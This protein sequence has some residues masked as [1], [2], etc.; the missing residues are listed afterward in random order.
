MTSRQHLNRRRTVVRAVF[1]KLGKTWSSGQDPSH[2]Y[3]FLLVKKNARTVGGEPFT[4]VGGITAGQLDTIINTS[5][6]NEE[7]ADRVIDL[8]V[9]K[10]DTVSQHTPEKVDVESLASSIED[11][12]MSKLT[13][14]LGQVASG[15]AGVQEECQPEEPEVTFELPSQPY[16]EPKKTEL[17]TWTERAKMCGC[18]PVQTKKSDPSQVDGRWKRRAQKAWDE[19]LAKRS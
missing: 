18:G 4:P 10:K 6:T 2:T 3:A 14:L 12:I 17:E 16:E 7:A 11:R 5:S 13:Q 19:Y 8:V 9:N 1:R 15:Q